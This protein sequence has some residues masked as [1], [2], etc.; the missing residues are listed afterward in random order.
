MK[1]SETYDKARSA[2]VNENFL[3]RELHALLIASEGV[4]HIISDEDLL[5]YLIVAE[6]RVEYLQ[7][8]RALALFMPDGDER[9]ESHTREIH[10]C[11]QLILRIWREFFSR[12]KVVGSRE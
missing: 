1:M 6:Q 9:R 4:Y 8:L 2:G 5:T 7:M 3:N 12:R 10:R 11:N